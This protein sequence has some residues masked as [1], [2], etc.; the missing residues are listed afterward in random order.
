MEGL[1][2]FLILKLPNKIQKCK[3]KVVGQIL[4][5]GQC[6][7][8]MCKHRPLAGA[9]GHAGPPRG[10]IQWVTFTSRPM[11]PVHPGVGQPTNY[12]TAEKEA[13]LPVVSCSHI[14]ATVRMPVLNQL[15]TTQQHGLWALRM[16]PA[17][18][19]RLQETW[20]CTQIESTWNDWTADP[21]NALRG[22][23]PCRA[24]SRQRNR[25]SGGTHSGVG[26]KGLLEKIKLDVWAVKAV[27][28]LFRWTRERVSQ[29]RQT[30]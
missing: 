2:S 7:A 19:G 25:T 9:R 8:V 27:K 10:A 1:D 14:R 16:R 12:L 15:S 13:P 4:Q 3:R 28:D 20:C 17:G 21:N 5:I 22:A 11:W 24:S 29:W 6:D 23:L 30:A 26:E 18:S